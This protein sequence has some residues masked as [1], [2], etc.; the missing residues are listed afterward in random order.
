METFCGTECKAG[1]ADHI[2]VTVGAFLHVHGMA[3]QQADHPGLDI[4]IGGF[5]EQQYPAGFQ[6]AAKFSQGAALIH[7][8]MEGLMAEHDVGARIG[9]GQPRAVALQQFDRGRPAIVREQARA[10]LCA[11]TSEGS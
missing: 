8:M 4:C 9:Q 5:S 10:A 11:S 6:Y 2:E 7:E 3:K 1:V